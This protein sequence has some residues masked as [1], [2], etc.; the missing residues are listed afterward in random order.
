MQRGF[1]VPLITD[2]TLLITPHLRNDLQTL[3]AWGGGRMGSMY[4]FTSLSVLS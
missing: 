4:F 1:A 2:F 3:K